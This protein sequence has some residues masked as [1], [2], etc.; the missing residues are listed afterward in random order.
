MPVVTSTQIVTAPLLQ[1]RPSLRAFTFQF[2]QDEKQVQ[3]KSIADDNVGL[4]KDG[5][6]CGSG[7]VCVAGS[8]VEMS[9]V[10]TP[11][12][13]PSNNHALQCSG[14]GDCTTTSICVCFAGWIGVACD[15]RSNTTSSQNHGLS[16]NIVIVPSIAEGRTLDTAT[17]LGILLIVGVILLLLLVCLLFCYRRRSVVE[18]PTS[19]D[20][21]LDESLPDQTQRSIKFGRMR[22]RRRKSNKH[23]YGAL[24][25]ITEADERDSASV[26]SRESGSQNAGSQVLFESHHTVP[27]NRADLSVPCSERMHEHIYADSVMIPNTSPY[28][29]DHSMGSLRSWSKSPTASA[30]RLAPTPLRLNNIKQLLRNLQ[31][32]DL[33]DDFCEEG[34]ELLNTRCPLEAYGSSYKPLVEGCGEEEL[35]GV[36]ADHDLGSNTESSRGYD[37]EPRVE[38]EQDSRDAI[39]SPVAR[40]TCN[41]RQSPSLFNDSFKLEMSSSVHT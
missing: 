38:V 17:L 6:T 12:N 7:R 14:H 11:V 9:S 3:C 31:S 22:K 28:H 36:E 16:R 33:A 41:F 23:V 5:S 18:I 10:S 2:Q 37:L 21:K 4:V 32:D 39:S 24:N 1:S 25:R 29:L 35:S 15:T 20:E 40:S 34:M 30:E 26:R 8:C 27:Y 13:C 19:S